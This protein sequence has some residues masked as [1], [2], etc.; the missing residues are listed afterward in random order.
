MGTAPPTFDQY[1]PLPNTTAK[2]KEAREDVSTAGTQTSTAINAAQLPYAGGKAAADLTDAQLK[3]LRDVNTNARDELKTFEA[4]E[5]VK[6]Y[7]QGMR[8]FTTA[9]NV[10]IGRA[11][12]QDLVTL[13]AK[14]QDPTGAVMQGDIERYNNL[15]TALQY[16]PQ[17]FRDQLANGGKFSPQARRDII[18]FMR[19][20]VNTYRLPYEETR[21]G[22]EARI[23]QFN[24]Q[25]VPLG[26]KPIE[27]DKI[28][29]GDPLKLYQPKIEAYDKK[30]EADRIRAEREAGTPSADLLT[31]VPE[32]AQIAGE[33]VKGWRLSPEAEA[34]VVTYSRQPNATPEGYAQLLADKAVA[35]GHVLPSQREDYMQR[36][37]RDT[38]DFFKQS[39]E[40]RAGIQGI[41]YSQI[42]KAASENAGLFEGVAQAAR[43]LP[44]SGVQL[45]EGLVALPKDAVISA[46]EGTRTGTIK[47]FTDLAMELG[48]GQLDGP[49]VT[50]FADAMKERYG[51]LDAIQ[52]TGIKD[53][54]GLLGDLSMLLTGGGTAAARAPGAFGRF[55]EKVA[56]AGRVIDPLSGTVAAVTEGLPALYTAGKDRM[57]GFVQGVEDLPTEI[58]G[59]P[60]GTGGAPIREA[61]GAGF[62]RGATGAP[63]PR[64]EAFTEAMREPELVGDDLVT[65]AREAVG[66]LRQQGSD[67]YT[68]L[69]TQFGKNPAPLDIQVVRDRMTKIKPRSYD[70]WSTR[71]GPRP[72]EHLAWEQ[73]NNFVEDYAIKAAKDPNLL[74]PLE[75]DQFKQDIY[76]VGSKIGGAYDRDASRIAGNAYNAVR[77]E[78]VRHDPIY[79]EAMR[80]YEK[81]AR[82]VQQLETTFG[83]A[84]ARGKQPNIESV[85]R[86]LQAAIGRNNANVS[87]GQRAG[88][89]ERLNELDPE[90]TITPTLAGT[91][92]SS[93]K[94]RGLNAAVTLGAGIPAAFANPFALLAA[95]AFMPRVVG[96]TAYGLGRVAGTG[97]R[98]FNAAAQS[99]FGQGLGATG[100]ALADLYQKYPQLFLAE[101]QAGSRLQETEQERLE[102]LYG[103]SVPS[104]PANVIPEDYV[105]EAQTTFVAPEAAPVAE[106]AP[107][108][109][110]KETTFTVGNITAKFDPVNNDFYDVKDPTRR[111]KELADFAN[112]S[113]NMYRGGTVQAFNKGGNKGEAQPASWVGP[114][115][116]VVKGATYAFGD[117]IEGLGRM[118]LSGQLSPA[119]YQAQVSRIR[120]Q[121][122]AYEDA[123]P[124]S[125]GYEIGGAFLPSL[126]PGMQ[127]A[128]A[129]RV[130]SLAAKV[131]G[132]TRAMSLAAKTSPRARELGRVGAESL[133]YGVGSADSMRQAPASIGQEAAFGYGMYGLPR[134]VRAGYRAVRKKK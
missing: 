82:E 134:G 61:A 15:Q 78:L 100:T 65:K 75:M 91:S 58:L 123:N 92:L 122:K 81:T 109:V 43:N 54:V 94:P 20:R 55:G 25:L 53:P 51:S 101:A 39:P 131:P 93:W 12:D 17:V 46:L 87:Y 11:G 108:P 35:E 29:P 102:R 84:V 49:T 33:D 40:Q 133:A 69:M 60:S 9:L 41:D 124:E 38:V 114:L 48:Q 97:K 132:V 110:D 27:I 68:K 90:G 19:N 50:A 3:I 22:F 117:E 80:A 115:R 59:F 103:I 128:T 104:V 111:V 99:P 106:A 72:A 105:P 112:L 119:A 126:I 79:A 24:D 66:N 130:T 62:E 118:L 21:K 120:A 67:T 127:G 86:K 34:E 1:Q 88:Q 70:T 6:T 89:A 23:G 83:L 14:V 85:T 45:L 2:R 37:A 96:E 73:M 74:M 129:A 47:T 64:S 42:D 44:E 26:I 31:G 8:Y 113:L 125:I 107:A 5:I 116:S 57:P 4:L 30:L 10:P 52:R 18:A 7:D 13:A 28:L 16:I 56:T 98:A 63:T 71:K 95:P 77:Q 36:T 121:Q 76:D 32:G